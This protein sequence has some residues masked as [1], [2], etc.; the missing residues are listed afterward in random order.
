[1][2]YTASY[3]I[4][5]NLFS[6]SFAYRHSLNTD[7]METKTFSISGKYLLW[8]DFLLTNFQMRSIGLSSGL[9]E[10]KK[11]DLKLIL[12]RLSPGIVQS[13][14]MISSIVSNY[15]YLTTRV[16]TDTA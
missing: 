11:F 16:A 9:L 5:H 1:M 7:S 2:L 6:V 13:F 8:M 4:A 10:M 14:V 3:L 15:D 12:C